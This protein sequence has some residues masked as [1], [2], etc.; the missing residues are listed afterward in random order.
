MAWQCAVLHHTIFVLFGVDWV[1]GVRFASAF[2]LNGASVSFVI[3]TKSTIIRTSKCI[4]D[5][6]CTGATGKKHGRHLPAPLGLLNVSSFQPST[7]QM[8]TGRITRNS[9]KCLA[10]EIPMIPAGTQKRLSLFFSW[11]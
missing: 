3:L 1:Y 11:K 5:I 10:F 9:S 8:T 6:L 4:T 7:F 2:S